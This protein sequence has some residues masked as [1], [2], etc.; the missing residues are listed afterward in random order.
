MSSPDPAQ[1]AAQ[2]EAMRQQWTNRAATFKAMAARDTGMLRPA[3]DLLVAALT[4]RPAMRVLDI[5]CGGGEPALSIAAAIAADSGH[6]TATDLVPEMLDAAQENAE[7]RG[8]TNLTFQ[9]ADAESLPFSDAS[10]DAAT[11]RFGVMLFPNV[12]Q[13]LGEMRRVLK[14]EGQLVCMV[15]GPPEQDA[16]SRAL[17]IVRKYVT[18]PPPTPPDVPHRFRF[19]APGALAEQLRTAGFRNVEDHLQ[20]IPVQWPGTTDEWWATMLRMNGAMRDAL[21]AL[22]EQ[23]RAAIVQEVFDA[24][25]AAEQQPG[26]ETSAVILATAIR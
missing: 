23:R 7:K 20:T 19:S 21:D 6:V 18:L 25:R 10:F 8:L 15:W 11:C 13:A 17:M 5:A 1:A 3:T 22:D 16:M 4:R 14:P 2:K 24:K 12:Q 9:L 26:G